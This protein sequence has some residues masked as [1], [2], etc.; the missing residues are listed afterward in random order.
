MQYFGNF[1]TKLQHGGPKPIKTR[2][3]HR[4]LCTSGRPSLVPAALKASAPPRSCLLDLD[5]PP[6]GAATP[7]DFSP[8]T[9]L[10]G[11]DACIQWGRC[12]V[13]CPAFAAG[14]PLNPKRLIQSPSRR[15]Q[16]RTPPNGFLTP[17]V[18]IRTLGLSPAS[19][20]RNCPSSAPG[21]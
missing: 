7:S 3:L 9:R 13:A 2:S 11:F 10:I 1:C 5:A 6:L 20:G 12:E 21:R 8:S 15:A 14:Q 17:A 19:A 16:P 4:L 18:P